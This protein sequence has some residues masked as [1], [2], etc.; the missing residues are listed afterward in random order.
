MIDSITCNKCGKT[1]PDN[2]ENIHISNTFG[3]Y[4]DFDME[5]HR[6]DLCQDCYKNLINSMTIPIEIEDNI[7][8]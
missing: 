1:I 8:G 3:Y 4:S 6:F 2:E 7:F 5:T